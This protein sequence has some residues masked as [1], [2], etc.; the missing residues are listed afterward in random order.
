[1]KMHFS[2]G[3]MEALIQQGQGRNSSLLQQFSLLT[4]RCQHRN[5]RGAERMEQVWGGVV[6]GR[7]CQETR[8]QEC[9][10]VPVGLKTHLMLVV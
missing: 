10:F 1:M 9:V 4:K 3:F 8:S 7:P 2:R 6:G 5:A